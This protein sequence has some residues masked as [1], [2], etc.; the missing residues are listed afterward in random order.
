V[1]SRRSREGVLTVR[2]SFYYI[3]FSSN[4]SSLKGE[5]FTFSADKNFL[6]AI[7][8][9]LAFAGVNCGTEVAKARR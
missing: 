7:L 6:R 2:T 8:V 5:A 4:A 1:G 3:L 9:Y